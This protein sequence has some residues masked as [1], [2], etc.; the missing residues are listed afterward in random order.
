MKRI[1]ALTDYKNV[2]GSKHFS[3]PYRSG[4]DKA[5]LTKFFNQNN[6]EIEFVQFVDVDFR[7]NNYHNKN[8]IYTSSE[9]INYSYKSYIEDI[10]YGLDLAGA[11][12]LPAYKYLKANNNKVFM[13]I[14][15]DLSNTPEFQYPQAKGFG[16][17]QEYKKLKSNFENYK[18]VKKAEGASGKGVYLTQKSNIDKIIKSVSRTKNLPHELWDAGRALK[19]K[20]YIKE[21]KHRKKFIIQ[22]FIPDLKNDW[23]IYIF[24]ERLYVFYRP[25][26]KNRAIKASGGGYDNYFYGSKANIPEGLF[27]FAHKIF[28]KLNVP[29]VSLDIGFDGE[30]FYM[31]EFQC[32]YFGTAGIPYS[33]EYF[34]KNKNGDWNNI[35][36]DL[37]QE[38]VYADS[39]IWYLNKQ[40]SD[41][42][43]SHQ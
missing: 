14:L 2:F 28:K 25:I 37:E 13:E 3:K 17:Y 39:I 40:K 18:I 31:F 32:I 43:T 9:D 21:S 1:I 15:R 4:F 7:K 8:I 20:G 19:H 34:M 26:F 33:K 22:E 30:Q 5:L 42:G 29:H 6:V 24:G 23:K 36:Q 35:K 27:D 38:K 12:I 16:N 11:N 10:V 41:E